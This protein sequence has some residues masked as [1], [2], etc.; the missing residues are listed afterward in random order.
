MI[1]EVLYDRK[2]GGMMVIKFEDGRKIVL[3]ENNMKNQ[4]LMRS[5]KLDE[6]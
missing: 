3:S 1:T 6:S 2:K 4:K 5:L